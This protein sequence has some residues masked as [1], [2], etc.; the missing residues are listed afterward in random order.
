[1]NCWNNYFLKVCLAFNE[2]LLLSFIFLCSVCYTQLPFRSTNPLREWILS[3]VLEPN[4]QG[5]LSTAPFIHHDEVMMM[6]MM[7]VVVMMMV[8]VVVVGDG[9]GD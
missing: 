4:L 2:W 9:E 7:T 8:V 1:M 3:F 5:A 6:M